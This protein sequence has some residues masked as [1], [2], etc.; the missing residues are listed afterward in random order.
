[1]S[2]NV[3]L[4]I[5]SSHPAS[6]TAAQSQM[7]NRAIYEASR[8]F[9][10]LRAAASGPSRPVWPD[11]PTS[12][13]YGPAPAP[14]NPS[15]SPGKDSEQMIQGICGRTF[16]GSSVPAG[17]LSSWENRL[18]ERLAIVGS[19]EFDLI[20][21][22]KTTPAGRSISRLAPSMR[23][24]SDSG[25]TGSQQEAWWTPKASQTMGRYSRVNGKIYPGLWM[26]AEDIHAATWTTPQAHDAALPDASRWGRHG[27]KHGGRDLNDE[28]A[29]VAT[30]PTPMAHEARLG[31]QHRHDGAKGSQKSL[32]TEAVDSLG[33]GANV[34]GD[35][36][37][38]EK[39]GALNPEF[40]CWLMGFTDEWV[41]SALAA[42]LSLPRSPRK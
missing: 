11:G 26:Q 21:K 19:T 39:R 3:S 20:W 25:S 8:K 13:S 2:S 9:I 14:A 35:Q 33:L 40:V 24:T 15:P 4:K 36:A 18:R 23:R 16:I 27:T 10:S 5:T 38:T 29:M 28:A 12:A 31:Y 1:M 32:T 42:M 34:N 30:W 6:L 41:S 22:E 37:Q 17:P 7:F